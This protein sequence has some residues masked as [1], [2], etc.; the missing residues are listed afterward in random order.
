MTK[1]YD[2]LKRAEQ[3]HEEAKPLVERGLEPQAQVPRRRRALRQKLIAAYQTIDSRLPDK[4]ARIVMFFSSRPGEG[5]SVLVRELARL[6]SA[7]LGQQVALID[8]TPAAGGHF[9]H[10]GVAPA[11]DGIAA[12]AAGTASVRDV[13][14]PVPDNP[15]LCLGWVAAGEGSASIAAV[16]KNLAGPFKVLRE[17][18]KLIL[19][20]MPPLAESSDALVM[21][22]LTDGVVLVV[23]AEKTRWQVAENTREK[24]AMQG[25]NLLGVILNKRRFY[26]PGFIYRR[27]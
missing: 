5:C 3:E 4:A 15:R 20:D 16:A 9:E 27:L 24:L 25:G 21:A 19:L 8:V 12:V 26:I 17:E 23:E 2:A 14:R 22:P 6:A 7:E 13:L 1:I 10:F 11:E 18:F